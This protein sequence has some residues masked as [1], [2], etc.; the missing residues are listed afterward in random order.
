MVP[1]DLK[2]YSLLIINTNKP[3]ALAESAYNQRRKECD[4]ALKIISVER[5]IENLVEATLDDLELISNPIFK[6]R[7]RHALTEQLRVQK[8]V[9]VLNSGSLVEFGNLM[10]ESHQSL[11]DDFE[12]SCAELDFVVNELQ[13]SDS[14][15]GAGMPNIF[16][17]STVHFCRI[18]LHIHNC[19]RA[20]KIWNITCCMPS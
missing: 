8:S 17:K 12:V 2:E 4:E 20:S 5:P 6:K 11:R 14:C 10:N 13:S 18:S 19:P 9:G 3:R 15:L 16:T 7:A 1:L